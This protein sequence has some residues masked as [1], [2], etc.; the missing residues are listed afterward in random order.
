MAAPPSLLEE[1]LQCYGPN[2]ALNYDQPIHMVRGSGS[3]LYDEEGRCYLDCVNNVAHVGHSNPAVAEA[4][5]SQVRQLNTNSRYLSRGLVEFS[6]QLL[7]LLPESMQVIYMT[8]SGS[9]AN[10]LAL[11]MSRAA[12]LAAGRPEAT[13]VAVMGGAYHGHLTTTM[14]ISPYKFWG[15]GG[16]GKEPWVH[17]LPCPDPYRGTHLDG[18]LAARGAIAEA[19]A[20]GG[21]ICAF[22][23]ESVLSCGGQVFPPEGYMAGVY[24]E[25]RAE[26]AVCIADEVQ[27]GFGRVGDAF[28]GFQLSGVTPDLVVMGKPIGNGF[29]LAAVATTRELAAAFSTQEYFNTYGGCNAAAAAGLAT[30]AEVRRLDLQRRAAEVGAHLMRRLR[31]LQARHPSMI[32]DVRGRGLFMGIDIVRDPI[33]KTP[34][35]ATAKWLKEQARARQVL[36][37]CDGPYEQV[38]KIKPPM[39]FSEE[40]AD[41]L[42]DTLTALFDQ[43]ASA[44]PEARAALAAAEDARA[45]SHVAPVAAHYD[46]NAARVYALAAGRA[47]AGSSFDG[48]SSALSASPTAAAA[49]AGAAGAAKVAPKPSLLR[50]VLSWASARSDSSLSCAGEWE[51]AAPGAARA[52]H[53]K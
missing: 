42:V 17:V 33:S 2:T 48:S 21:R 22:I 39:V 6:K 28:W 19:R 12:A 41:L 31:E 24:E 20:A 1:R 11:R 38:I 26:G 15:R 18:R 53:A 14:A 43:L 23:S 37:S 5:C 10:D 16:A 27:C 35:P 8:N 52:V 45:A 30:L 51:M 47:G 13:H 46:G 36:L 29:P 3:R 32:G 50:R 4:V 25:M 49:A 7:E 40:D 44:G 9:E 34:A